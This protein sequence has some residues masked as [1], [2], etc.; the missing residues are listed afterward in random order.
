MVGGGILESLENSSTLYTITDIYS[1]ISPART[2]RD[3]N[4]INVNPSFH[5][6]MRTGGSSCG[7]A[8]ASTAIILGHELGHLMGADDDGPGKMN[9]VNQYENP[10]G[11]ELGLPPRTAY[12]PLDYGFWLPH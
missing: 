7:A 2:F 10:I 6:I 5:P 4:T 3:I 8:G 9:N 1:G 12:P 11:A